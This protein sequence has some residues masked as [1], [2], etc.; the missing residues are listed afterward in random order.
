MRY[1]PFIKFDNLGKRNLNLVVAAYIYIGEIRAL[2][3]KPGY[4]ISK[5]I[6][7]K[8]SNDE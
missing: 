8:N 3:I 7:K 6:R 5:K 2:F 4:K 1:L